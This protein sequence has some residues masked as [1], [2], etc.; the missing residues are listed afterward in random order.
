[1]RFEI[2]IAAMVT[3][4]AA[5]AAERVGSWWVSVPTDVLK[6]MDTSERT[7]AERAAK[8]LDDR[9]YKSAANEWK[10]FN[11]EFI[12]TASEETLAWASF[13]QAFS[14]DL[15]KDR[16]KAIELYAETMELY[17][18]SFAACA[19]LF[20]RAQAEVN[21]GQEQK[22]MAS[23]REL[24]DN[25]VFATHALAY[26][27]HNRIAWSLIRKSKLKEAMEELQACVGL[28]KEG[29]REEWDRAND[30]LAI[31]ESLADPQAKASDIAG[32]EDDKPEKRYE[33]LRRWHRWIWNEVVC[34]REVVRAY[35]QNN[36]GKAKD[37]REAEMNYLKRFVSA[38]STVATPIYK[39]CGAEWEL[40]MYEFEA[41]ELLAPKNL[42]KV[43]NKIGG[44]VRKSADPKVRSDRAIEFI[45]Q[46]RDVKR[47]TDAKLFLDLI[48]DP[49]SRG[50]VGADIGWTAR[51][52]K[53]IAECLAPLEAMPDPAVA[54]EAKR[55]HARSC[56][57]LARDYDTA[58]K[59]YEEAPRP[60]ETLWR[61]AECHR[62]AGR[63]PKAQATL[64]EICGVFP[65]DAAEAMLRKG[66]WY[67]DDGDKKNAIGCYRRILA[68]QEWKKAGAA[69]AAHQRLEGYGIATGGAVLNEVH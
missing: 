35:F 60:P 48:Q 58:I 43:I 57:E 17:P 2:L 1:M 46:L 5:V 34:D 40:L 6:S 45:K 68:H 3:A 42:D 31:V 12:T 4:G 7:C 8:A 25:P 30:S 16:Y 44:E 69:S 56:Q 49:V 38:F 28:P 10:R 26:A 37:V 20:F 47:T 61:I 54:D 29:N 36:L 24:L 15:A 13:F 32:A 59:L 39:A 67:R 63:K 14:L 33:R 66:D 21:N 23:Y 19:S 18:E 52:P 55:N 41:V 50:K 11:S 22:G 64:D 9:N 51:D 53:F 65:K 27:A 62:A